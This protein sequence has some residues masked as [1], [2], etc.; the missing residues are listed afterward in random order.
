MPAAS[1]AQLFAGLGIAASGAVGK[2]SL[3]MFSCCV[4]RASQKGCKRHKAMRQVAQKASEKNA[5]T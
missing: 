4:D 3:Q 2:C 1:L 5:E